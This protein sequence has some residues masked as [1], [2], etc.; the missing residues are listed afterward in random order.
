MEKWDHWHPRFLTGQRLRQ[1]NLTRLDEES[2]EMVPWSV[3]GKLAYQVE[4]DALI[5]VNGKRELVKAGQFPRAERRW[6]GELQRTGR[7]VRMETS[8]DDAEELKNLGLE[9]FRYVYPKGRLERQLS[10]WLSPLTRRS[11]ISSFAVAPTP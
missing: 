3:T 2:G 9:A 1:W 4:N 8:G 6:F 7:S 10:K 5:E 11:L